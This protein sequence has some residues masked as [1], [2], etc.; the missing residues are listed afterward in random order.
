MMLSVPVP[1]S[2]SRFPV[3]RKP[4]LFDDDVVVDAPAV[5]TP[6]VLGVLVHVLFALELGSHPIVIATVVI[7][8]VGIGLQDLAVVGRRV[9]L[10]VVIVVVVVVPALALV[11]ALVLAAG[12]HLLLKFLEPGHGLV[13]PLLFA[14]PLLVAVLVGVPGAA[15]FD[16][17]HRFGLFFF[18]VLF[19]S[20]FG[21][22]TTMTG[23]AV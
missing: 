4:A 11:L 5:G 9:A 21:M 13:F 6:H 8:T 3:R 22:V 2:F 23:V 12:G 18:L 7:A 16:E 19:G 15:R 17:T 1:P 20:G 14:A 10:A